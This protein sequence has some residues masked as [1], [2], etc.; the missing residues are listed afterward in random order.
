MIE[1]TDWIVGG[2]VWASL[3]TTASKKSVFN[4]EILNPAEDTIYTAK[5]GLMY[6]SDYYYAASPTY[7]NYVGNNNS[8]NDYQAA[9]PY[10]WLAG[11]SEQT[12][13]RSSEASINAF[14]V[15]VSGALRDITIYSN[16]GGLRPTF[17]LKTN[18]ILSS[19]D[20][21]STN[22]YRLTLA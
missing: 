17:Y 10:N 2:N 1:T 6:V 22:P 14:Y 20:G 3:G 8:S 18:I 13:T 15:D 11:I 9:K 16:T 5:I 21:S 19:G 7:W 12:I 4:S